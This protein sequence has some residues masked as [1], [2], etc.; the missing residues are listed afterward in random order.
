MI[1]EK[2]K[3]TRREVL[4]KIGLGVT[5][6]AVPSVYGVVLPFPSERKHIITLSFDD[7]FKKSSIKTAEIFEKHG[8]QACLNVIATAHMKDFQLPNEYHRWPAGDFELWNEIKARGHEI[9]PHGYKHSNLSKIPLAEAIDLIKA[10]LEVFS[11][12]LKGFDPKQ[13]V[14]N[15]PHNASSLEVEDWLEVR[16]KAFRTG[17][18]AVNP[19]PYK[20]QSKLT[21][22][23]YGPGNTEDHLEGE[24]T[25]LLSLSTGWLIYNTH[26]LD[27]E[28]WGPM[29][30]DFLDRLLARLVE[31]ESVW[32]APAGVVLDSLR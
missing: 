6:M 29:G 5:A 9:M 11:R 28:G 7:G 15:F 20:G 30:S 8:L 25:K 13:T 32:V 10:C 18:P 12:E 21:C 24:I 4:K 19:L 23:G 17:G 1:K 31:I 22:T 26:G 16:V 27:D 2:M 14:F 3:E